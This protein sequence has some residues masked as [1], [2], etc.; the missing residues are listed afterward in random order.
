MTSVL[1]SGCLSTEPSDAGDRSISVQGQSL[2]ASSLRAAVA[3]LCT[4]LERLPED[5]VAARDAFFDLAHDHLHSIAAAAQRVDRSAAA[6]LLQAK[7]V[8]E[9]DLARSPFPSSLTRDLERLAAAT[10]TALTA[11]SIRSDAC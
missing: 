6:A 11:M 7:A 8:V 1:T 9:E 5:P 2:S 10:R 3:G 4:S